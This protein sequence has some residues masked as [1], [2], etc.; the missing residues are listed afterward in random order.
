MN[1]TAKQESVPGARSEMRAASWFKRLRVSTKLYFIVGFLAAILVFIGLIGLKGEASAVAG[2]DSVYKDRVVPLGDLKKISDLYA[3]NIVDTS[4][5]VRNGNISW[6]QARDNIDRAGREIKASW[7][8]YLATELDKQEQ[9][10]I[11]EIEPLMAR[12]DA[13]AAKLRDILQREDQKAIDEFT[14]KDLYPVIDPLTDAL[15][16]LIDIQIKVA[17]DV[18][19]ASESEYLAIRNLT[20]VSIVLGLIAGLALALTIIRGLRRELG[21]EPAYVAEIARNVAEGNLVIAIQVDRNDRGSVLT[22]MKGMVEKLKQ[23]KDEVTTFTAAAANGELGKRADASLFAGDW[24]T[25]VQGVNDTVTHIVTPLKMTA[26]YIER[27]AMGDIPSKITETYR[28]D[29][30]V[31]KNNLNHMVDALQALIADVSMLDAAGAAGNLGVRADG[32][33]HRGEYQRIV[34]GMNA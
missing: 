30:N 25:L 11:S 7:Q 6:S 24:R 13:T 33:R 22:S 8:G 14:I 28:G 10:L 26:D 2:L 31:I 32:S 12:G 34:E 4:H 19:D 3:V 9:E 17:K 29:F 5:K 20:I 1:E 16:K 15:A 21:G 23:I 27:I 18:Y